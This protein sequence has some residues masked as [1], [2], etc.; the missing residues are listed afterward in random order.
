VAGVCALAAGIVVP[1]SAQWNAAG[2][3]WYSLQATT[4][5]AFLSYVAK[6]EERSGKSLANGNFLWVDDLDSKKCAEVYARLQRGEVVLRRLAPKEGAERIEIPGGMIHDWQGIVFV[7]GANLNR[8][9]EVLQDYNHHATYYAPDVEKS[10]IE[11]RNGEQ[12]RVFMRFRRKK[13]ITV[14]LDT[15]QEVNYFRNSATRA[16]SRSSAVRIAE[17]EDPG[18]PEEKEKQPGEDSG[19]LWR[20]ETWWRMEEKDGGVYVQNEVVSLTRDVPTGLGWL[21]EPF[22]NSIPKESLEFTMG[23]TR[24]AVLAQRID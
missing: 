7:P 4:L 24:K 8:V 18:R 23:A 3:G 14:V 2:H 22:L 19:Y 17:V 12:F 16:N 1:A 6:T 9:L 15:E 20:M 5:R 11:S 21:I 13:V 10:T